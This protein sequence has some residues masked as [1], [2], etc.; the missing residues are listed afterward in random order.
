MQK[1]K[2]EPRSV[3]LK[4]VANLLESYK[5]IVTKE[6]PNNLPPIREIS[7]NIGLIPRAALPSNE[8]YKLTPK[9]MKK[10]PNKFRKFWTKV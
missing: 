4:E 7:H 10:W 3:G 1:K 8:A 6:I 2:E 9:K 5:D